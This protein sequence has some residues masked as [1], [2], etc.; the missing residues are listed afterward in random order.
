MEEE[1]WRKL[2]EIKANIENSTTIIYQN[3]VTVTLVQYNAGYMY[4][5]GV[6]GT[7]YNSEFSMVRQV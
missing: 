5:E 3:N 6:L 7:T 4:I 1:R 2:K